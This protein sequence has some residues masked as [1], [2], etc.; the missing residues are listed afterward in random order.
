MFCKKFRY[1]CFH[2]MYHFPFSVGFHKEQSILLSTVSYF[3]YFWLI[4]L[5]F[6]LFPE[7]VIELNFR[8]VSF[9]SVPLFCQFFW[10]LFPLSLLESLLG[11]IRGQFYI[12]FD[13]HVNFLHGPNGT[14]NCILPSSSI[15]KYAKLCIY[16]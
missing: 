10:L 1:F 9:S 3:R 4:H 7:R 14:T 13:F 12:F 2:S 16:L 8:I 15:W 11:R 5:L 6:F